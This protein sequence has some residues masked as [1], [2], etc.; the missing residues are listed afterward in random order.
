LFENR[1]TKMFPSA[2]EID[3]FPQTRELVNEVIAGSPEVADDFAEVGSGF[4]KK[5]RV[6]PVSEPNFT[7]AILVAIGSK[8]VAVAFDNRLT[9]FVERV[10]VV[11]SPVPPR[12]TV[13]K[14]RWH[15]ET[16]VGE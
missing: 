15:S 4:S 1:E 2:R 12:P 11:A 13:G 8:C 16:L 10:H 6:N 9:G 5:L 7:K 14:R 3:A